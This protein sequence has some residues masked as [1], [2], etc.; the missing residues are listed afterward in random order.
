MKQIIAAVS[1]WN[2]ERKWKLFLRLFPLS[3]KARILDVGFSEEEWSA[4]DN[5]IEKYYPHPSQLTA[6]GIDT[7]K[8]FLKRYP[9]VRAV[10]YDGK[11]FPFEDASFDICWSNAVVEHVGDR[12]DQVRFLREIKRVS[13][14][15]FVTTPNKYFPLELHTRVPFLHFLLPKSL[16]DRYLHWIG[17]SWA[18]GGYMQ[19]LSFRDLKSLLADAGIQDYT[20]KRMR[21][22]GFTMNYI[23]VF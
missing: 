5:F 19:L 6:L 16:F 23:I 9:A 21:V 20:I 4:Q 10:Q 3:P 8:E 7:P 2:R 15:A 18:T 14:G 1:K 11:T 12:E 17:K 22:L 13:K